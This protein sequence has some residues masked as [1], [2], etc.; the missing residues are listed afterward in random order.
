MQVTASPRTSLDHVGNHIDQDIDNQPYTGR[1]NLAPVGSWEAGAN[2][3]E[4]D[5]DDEIVIAVDANPQGPQTTIIHSAI[6]SP[7]IPANTG[8][9]NLA[10]AQAG[11]GP[12]PAPLPAPAGVTAR[13]AAAARVFGHIHNATVLVIGTAGGLLGAHGVIKDKTAWIASGIPLMALGMFLAVATVPARRHQD[14][15]ANVFESIY[16]K[17]G[18]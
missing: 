2:T 14:Q 3:V 12:V 6:L 15:I 11:P 16:Q 1:N 8:G 13:G 9:P 4:D 5:H 10:A 17:L 18:Y 7:A